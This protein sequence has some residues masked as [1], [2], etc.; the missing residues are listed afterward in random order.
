MREIYEEIS[1]KLNIKIKS[2]HEFKDG[3]SSKVFLVNNIYLLKMND[4]L[5]GEA[6]FLNASKNS[7]F[8]NLIYRGK[9]FNIY[10]YIKGNMMKRVNKPK[11]LMRSLF[12]ITSRYQ[13]SNIVGYG[14]LNEL[15]SKWTEF[16]KV[17]LESSRFKTALNEEDYVFVMKCVNSL[18]SFRFKSRLLHGDFGTHNFV[19]EN[20]ILIGVIDPQGLVGDYMY[21]FLFG[22]V[23]NVDIISNITVEEILEITHENPKKI[24]ALLFVVLYNR[25]NRSIKYHPEDTD[26]YVKIWNNLRSNYGH[27]ISNNI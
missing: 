11:E 18:E 22:L 10:K 21:D 26:E 16:L 24:M 5:D 9:N 13:I 1:K 27:Y 19:E 20:D 7:V 4:G 3:T 6:A 23:S 25:I 17:E 8:Q 2:V 14:Y 12:N 15:H